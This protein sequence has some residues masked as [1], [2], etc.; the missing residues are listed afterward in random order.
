M[1]NVPFACFVNIEQRAKYRRETHT[2]NGDIIWKGL[3]HVATI[4]IV[5]PLAVC[6]VIFPLSFHD[7][8]RFSFK[9]FFFIFGFSILLI[10]SRMFLTNAT[11]S[12]LSRF[13][14]SSPDPL[15]AN[16]RSEK[17]YSIARGFCDFVP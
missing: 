2:L 9:A 8:T 11:D 14:P 13:F 10:S 4:Y 16:I 3:C 5:S 12:R 7:L 15:Q 17:F 6:F 1:H